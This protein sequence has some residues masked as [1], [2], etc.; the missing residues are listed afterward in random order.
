[1]DALGIET[2][3]IADGEA[4]LSVSES[5]GWAHG[6]GDWTT[7]LRSGIVFGHRITSGE[8]VS[9]TAVFPYGS[10]L[11]TIGMVIVK[12]AWQGRGLARALMLHAFA[13]L[14]APAPLRMLIATEQGFP[15]YRRLGFRTVGHVHRAVAAAPRLPCS[16]VIDPRLTP[17]ATSDV[18]AIRRLDADAIGADR[19]PVL[20][21]RLAQG[22]GVALR[23]D[24]GAIVGFGLRVRQ[25]DLLLAG[26]VV[27]ADAVAAAAVVAGLCGGHDGR[28]RIDVPTGQS[29]F[30]GWLRARGF[31][32]ADEAP[33]MIL[34]GEALP[35]RRER[36][37]A[38]AN[39]AFC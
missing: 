10:A 28:I 17:L 36:V 39:R 15:L 38:V 35:G 16:A 1:M 26:P 3:G 12:P 13:C 33:V 25:R 30:L 6:P 22:S 7:M 34:D 19:G 20:A 37:F 21:A 32:T 8:I 4:L 11:A 18:E 31:E 5:V 27:A 29:E 9:S 23:G 2:F 24:E 14:P